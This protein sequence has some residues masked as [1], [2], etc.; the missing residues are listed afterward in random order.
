MST[1]TTDWFT[2]NIGHWQAAIGTSH[3]RTALELGVFEGRS[4]VW[5]LDNAIEHVTA[6]DWWDAEWLEHRGHY[7]TETTFDHNIAPYG[8]RVTKVKSSTLAFLKATTD[9]FDLIYIDGGHAGKTVIT[10]AVLAHHALV[11]SGLLIFD[12]YGQE[13]DPT[14]I[15]RARGA[16][17]HFMELFADDYEPIHI[18]YQVILRKH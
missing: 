5:M 1:F 10:D 15:D 7:D 14:R 18:G 4:V 8:D 9:T 13:K 2:H 16:I 12:D 17:D 6:V 3:I 11:P